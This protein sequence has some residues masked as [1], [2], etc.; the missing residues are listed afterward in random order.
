MENY[1][2]ANSIALLADHPDLIPLVARWHYGEWSRGDSSGPF[3]LWV[4]RIESRANQDRI[5]ITYLAFVD[6]VPTGTAMLIASDMDTHPELAP[7]LA[8]V[9]VLPEYRRRGIASALVRHA[10][11][12]AYLLG[13]PILYLYTNGAE[14]VYENLG[15]KTWRREE[16]EGR[17]VTVMEISA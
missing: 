6:G 4:E 16:Y 1:L 12:Q 14:R 15:W 17:M 10:V 11:G 2:A 8:G 3:S 13:F 9:F 5:P 7:W